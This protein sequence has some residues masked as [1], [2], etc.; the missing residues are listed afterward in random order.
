M[1]S[2]FYQKSPYKKSWSYAHPFSIK[3]KI[4]APEWGAWLGLDTSL[5]R[6]IATL[7]NMRKYTSNGLNEIRKT[8]KRSRL[9]TSN[10]GWLE[11]IFSKKLSFLLSTTYRLQINLK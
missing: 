8:W 5:Q 9:E 4:S 11:N 1:I 7:K 2:F 10:P 3:T 6:M